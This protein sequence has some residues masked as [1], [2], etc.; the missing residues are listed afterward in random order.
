MYRGFGGR[1]LA[2]YLVNIIVGSMVGAWAFE[3]LF[4]LGGSHALM[5]HEH[6]TPTAVVSAVVLIAALV[7]FAIDDLRVWVAARRTVEPTAQRLELR[8]DGM[9]CGGCARKLTGRLQDTAGVESVEISLDPGLAV[10][11]G[12]ITAEAARSVI[13]EAGFQPV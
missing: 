10:V 9:T 6:V 8:V 1:A 11:H 12:S 2:V 13:E 7:W 3:A 4:Q 5:D